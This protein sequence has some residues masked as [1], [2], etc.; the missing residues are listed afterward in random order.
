MA[1]NR[2]SLGRRKEIDQGITG[3]RHAPDGEKQ[4]GAGPLPH[5]GGYFNGGKVNQ[6]KGQP[7]ERVT[8][9]RLQDGDWNFQLDL[10]VATPATFLK[11]PKTAIDEK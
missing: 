6:I 1:D 11:A 4:G 7:I 3:E 5:R 10:P 8:F 9:K 2:V